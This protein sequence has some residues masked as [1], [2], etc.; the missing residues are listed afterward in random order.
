MLINSVFDKYSVK[1]ELLLKY[2]FIFDNNQYVYE[3]RLEAQDFNLRVIIT[4][5]S[6]D[7][8]VFENN[9]EEYLPFYIKKNSGSFVS[10]IKE[11]VELIIRDILLNCFESTNIRTKLITYVKDKYQSDPEYP[12]KKDPLSATL[13]NPTSNKWFG[14]I[15]TIP[16]NY[17]NIEK[18]GKIDVLN[19]KNTPEKI[20][21]L[22]DHQHFF[23]AYHMNKKYWVTV[24]LD[25]QVDLE[26]VKALLDDSYQLVD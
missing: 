18:E 23:P 8:K 24:L 11:E 13:K 16:Y 9:E 14:L 2:G 5:N 21:A 4:N 15:M 3:K 22:I 20:M 26:Q 7:I 19:I 6:F 12:W 17:L 25:S 10:K 1:E